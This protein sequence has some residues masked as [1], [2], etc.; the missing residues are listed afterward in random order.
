M[1]NTVPVPILDP[2][3]GFRLWSVDEIYDGKGPGR[4][5]PNLGDACWDWNTGLYRVIEV[6]YTTGLSVLQKYTPPKDAGGLDN[7]DILLG[8]G[9]GPVSESYRVYVDKS[10]MP[11]ILAVDSRLRIY[12]T[13][14]TLIKIFKGVDISSNGKVISRFYDQN[15]SLICED[16]PL[17]T[18]EGSN[19][20]NNAVKTPMVG[21]TIDDLADGELVTAV[22]YDD[23]GNAVSIAR[24]LVK[25][26]AFIRTTDAAKKYITGIHIESPF[27]SDDDPRV[28]QYPINMPTQALGMMGVVTYSDGGVKRLPID[29]TKFSLYG[30]DN[31]V[32]TILGQRIPLVLTYRLS[33]DEVNY[34]AQSSTDHYITEAYSATTVEVDGAY[35]VKLFVYPVWVDAVNGYRLEYFLYNLD[36]EDVYR[37]TPHVNLATNS[38]AFNPTLYGVT[39]NITLAVNLN[40]VNGR[41]A[42]YRHVQTVGI[43]LL[44]RGDLDVAN[45]TVQ[46]TPNLE[47]IYGGEGIAARIDFINTEFWKLKIDCGAVTQGQWLESLYLPAQPLFNPNI[48]AAP[49][50]PNFFN[51]VFGNRI[52]EYPISQW[53]AELEVPNDLKEG[54]TLFIEF[55]RRTA[56]TDL[57]LATVGLPVHQNVTY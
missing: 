55:F 18:V 28:L 56:T 13:T 37:A 22:V 21:Y 1:S 57:R 51:L 43:T 36:R 9:P 54:Q 52:I 48:E 31:Y 42:P 8:A 17:E 24:L 47:P 49:P 12:G 16:I 2:G 15:G 6:D 44:A 33:L 14:P 50:E 7:T 25:N 29:G 30:L 27:I 32:A 23:A 3:R 4:Y 39:Q 40:E 19:S 53:N 11:H 34:N 20:T 10:V 41:F 45:W 5:V 46:Y 38:A 35:T 26:T